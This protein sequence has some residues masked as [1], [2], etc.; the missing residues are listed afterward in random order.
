MASN[1]RI[2]N[3]RDN[4]IDGSAVQ[5]YRFGINNTGAHMTNPFITHLRAS[6]SD[7][8]LAKFEI[9]FAKRWDWQAELNEQQ[10]LHA[11]AERARSFAHEH[12][13]MAATLRGERQIG[14]EDPEATASAIAFGGPL[15]VKVS[16]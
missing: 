14:D 6:S 2:R 9:I 11:A 15:P 1:R 7:E 5:A 13:L 4:G 12:R 8:G 3:G 16:A 10:G